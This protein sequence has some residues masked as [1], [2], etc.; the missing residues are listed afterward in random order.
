MGH[1]GKNIRKFPKN[2]FLGYI[3]INKM[4]EADYSCVAIVY[5]REKKRILDEMDKLRDNLKELQPE[6]KFF[7]LF[8][9]SIDDFI[10]EQSIKTLKN[11]KNKYYKKLEVAPAEGT[12]LWIGINPPPRKYTLLE[13]DQLMANAIMKYKFLDKHAYTIEAHTDNG[14]RPHIHL[15]T[16]SNDKPNRVITALSNHFKVDK[17]SIECKAYH[18]GLLFG[19]HYD[20]ITGQK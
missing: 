5:N 17:P 10:A 9:Q 4:E 18:K 20:Y 1:L 12:H 14:Y 3:Y 15:M 8:S 6:E 16:T 19:E 13:L 7:D 11:L 2:F